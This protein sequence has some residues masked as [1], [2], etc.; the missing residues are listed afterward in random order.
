MSTRNRRTVHPTRI[1]TTRITAVDHP[2]THRPEPTTEAASALNHPWY[3]GFM[4]LAL[5]ASLKLAYVL[6]LG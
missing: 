6:H 2:Q 5:L 1:N 3:S 4:V